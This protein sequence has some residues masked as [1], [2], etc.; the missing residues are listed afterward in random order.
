MTRKEDSVVDL[1]GRLIIVFII[2]VVSVHLLDLK[3]PVHDFLCTVL[4]VPQ[5]GH[6]RNQAVY[7]IGKICIFLITL[8]GIIKILSRGK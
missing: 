5:P 1:G 4:T 7:H 3:E 2:A 8:V 6:I